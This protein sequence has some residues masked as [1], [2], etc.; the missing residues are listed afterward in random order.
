MKDERRINRTVKKSIR[1]Y[2]PRGHFLDPDEIE[3]I[4]SLPPSKGSINYHPKAIKHVNT[5]P[6]NR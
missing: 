2:V 4:E 6:P 1:E 3:A 5:R